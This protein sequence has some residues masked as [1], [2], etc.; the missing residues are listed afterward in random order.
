MR[1]SVALAC[2]LA[3][4]ML[5]AYQAIA[6][7]ALH[8]RATRAS[9]WQA[10]S[11]ILLPAVAHIEPSAWQPQALR[12]VLASA[13]IERGDLALA[14]RF[15]DRLAEGSDRDAML[16]MLA[17][18]RGDDATAV[19]AFLAA[20][21]LRAIGARVDALAASGHLDAAVALQ[22]DV[23]V[24]LE[25]TH[26]QTDTLAEAL[27]RT[28]VLAQQRAYDERDAS[29]RAAQQAMSVGSYARA[30]KLAPLEERY[31]IALANEYLNTNDLAAARVEFERLHDLDPT[32]VEAF[33]GLADAAIRARDVASARRYLAQARALAPDSP[34][35][36][37]MA[38]KLAP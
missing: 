35:V 18:A 29:A 38:E 32:S 12:R 23:V 21:D 22:N 3:I 6:S 13:A 10:E 14:R 16:G 7:V 25:A 34:A 2:A 28:G 27:Y 9:L 24:R 4:L 30:L 33:T 15:V 37:H 19:R 8:E 11:A 17:Q 31:R 20:G 26:A 5:G 36:A 1:L